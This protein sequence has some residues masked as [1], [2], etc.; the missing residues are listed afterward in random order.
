MNESQG[1]RIGR[2]LGIPIYLDLSWILIFSLL[3]WLI[4]VQFG[5]EYPKWSY[6][7]TVGHRRAHQFAFFWLR[8]FS[9]IG[10]QRGGAALQN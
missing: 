10:A 7:R 1:I 8:A 3:T 4:S 9:R 2:V 6:H 5:K